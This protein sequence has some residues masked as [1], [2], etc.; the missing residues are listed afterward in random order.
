MS[1]RVLWRV[2][3]LG[4]VAV[5]AMGGWCVYRGI[6]DSLHAECGLHATRLVTAVVTQFIDEHGRWPRSW[7][8][9]HTV[10]LSDSRSMYSWP[11]DLEE[12]RQYVAVDFDADVA[13]IASQTAEKFDAIAP[14]GPSYVYKGDPLFESLLEKAAELAGA[15]N[16]TGESPR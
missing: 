1:K 8:E 14:I 13:D 6:S 7:E 4:V 12:V 15:S 10:S 5:A 2:C 3:I 16:A 11:D 9:L